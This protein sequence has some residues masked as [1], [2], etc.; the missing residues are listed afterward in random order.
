MGSNMYL[1]ASHNR[2]G[3]CPRDAAEPAGP[4]LSSILIPT[5]IMLRP[6]GCGDQGSKSPAVLF[7]HAVIV[8]LDH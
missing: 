3:L 2:K 5:T 1:T 6:L 4:L 7:I 8:F